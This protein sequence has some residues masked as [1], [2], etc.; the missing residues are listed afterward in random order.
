MIQ[1]AFHEGKQ[2]VIRIEG[3]DHRHDFERL[4]KEI[5]SRYPG[6]EKHGGILSLPGLLRDRYHSILDI[7]GNSKDIIRIAAS[8]ESLTLTTSPG[9]VDHIDVLTRLLN[10]VHDS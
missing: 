1:S 8:Q 5:K 9:A 2:A 7:D 6:T 4:V 3:R 10:K